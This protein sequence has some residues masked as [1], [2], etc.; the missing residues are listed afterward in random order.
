MDQIKLPVLY[1]QNGVVQ[2]SFDADAF[3]PESGTVLEVE[4]GRGYANNQFLK[5]FFQACMMHEAC[6]LVIAVRNHY[7]NIRDYDKVVNGST[8]FTPL[9]G[10]PFHSRQLR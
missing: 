10:L 4:A 3:H 8:R 7:R 5:D 1:G 6:H 9:G 2:K